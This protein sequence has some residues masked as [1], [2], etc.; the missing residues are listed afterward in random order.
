MINLYDQ[1]YTSRSTIG[2]IIMCM[3]HGWRHCVQWLHVVVDV[4]QASLIHSQLTIFA[5][6][7]RAVPSESTWGG[8]LC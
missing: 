7:F 8:N 1:T 5:N 4:P 2:V 6:C 3:L